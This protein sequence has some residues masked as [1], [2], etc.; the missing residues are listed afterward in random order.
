[1]FQEFSIGEYLFNSNWSLEWIHEEHNLV[2]LS[3]LYAEQ[4]NFFKLLMSTFSI[5]IWIMIALS[6][7]FITTITIIDD[8]FQSNNICINK[9]SV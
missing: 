7:L 9:Y 3:A 6:I 4:N 5:K 8:K 1:M 2:I